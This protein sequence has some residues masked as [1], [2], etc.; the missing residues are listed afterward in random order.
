MNNINTTVIEKMLG[1]GDRSPKNRGALDNPNVKLDFVKSDKSISS[2]R[3]EFP[4]LG[5]SN[6]NTE[7]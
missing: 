3:K 4:S 1:E 5:Y 6:V 7:G 2:G